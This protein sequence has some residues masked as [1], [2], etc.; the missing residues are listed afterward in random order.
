[1]FIFLTALTLSSNS[2]AEAAEEQDK[3][4]IRDKSETIVIMICPTKDADVLQKAA[5]KACGI[6][7]L[8][9]VWIWDDESKAP[10]K[11]PKID[12]DIA[13]I[14]SAQAVAIWVNDSKMFISLRQVKK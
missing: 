5:E 6:S 3:C 7:L 12:T 9:N 10:T 14:N 2:L 1:M 11:A 13:K 4:S 8:C